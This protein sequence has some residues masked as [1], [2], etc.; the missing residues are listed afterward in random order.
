MKKDKRRSKKVLARK[1]ESY[2][3][4]KEKIYI[5]DEYG[6]KRPDY[7]LY[8]VENFSSYGS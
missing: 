4:I 3:Y 5:E 6:H 8:V 7:K 2:Y 1:P